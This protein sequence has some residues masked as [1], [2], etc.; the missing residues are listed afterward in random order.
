[1]LAAAGEQ[2]LTLRFLYDDQNITRTEEVHTQRSTGGEQ[3]V[4][5]R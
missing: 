4:A 3:H 5:L 2:E 1:M